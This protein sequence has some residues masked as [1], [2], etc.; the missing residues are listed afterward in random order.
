MKFQIL[1][2]YCSTFFTSMEK[3]YK[4]INEILDFVEICAV[5]FL[6]GIK[7]EVFSRSPFGE[8]IQKVIYGSPRNHNYLVLEL[9]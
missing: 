9:P 7:N 5:F 1:Y 6:C 8:I 3:N 4:S 2:Y